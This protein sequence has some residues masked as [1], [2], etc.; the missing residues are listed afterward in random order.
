MS[1]HHNTTRIN[2]YGYG[3]YT[4][5]QGDKIDPMHADA[6]AVRL[7]VSRRTGLLGLTWTAVEIIAEILVQAV[8]HRKYSPENSKQYLGTAVVLVSFLR[9]RNVV[10]QFQRPRRHLDSVQTTRDR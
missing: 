2:A 7:I 9:P 3:P 1:M 5:V 4:S 6:G 8:Q 10:I